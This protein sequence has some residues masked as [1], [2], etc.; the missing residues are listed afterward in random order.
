[1][2]IIALHA[3]NTPDK[4]ALVEGERTLTW[5]DLV[6]HRNRL[7]SALT[8]LGVV[9]GER[10]VVYSFN[11]IE[12][13]L[14]GLAATAVGCVSVPM[15]HRLTAEEAA[16]V[17]DNS[18]AVAV[19]VGD[20]FLPVVEEIRATA[21]TK[22]RH[23]ILVGEER[24]EW[25]EHIDDLLAAGRPE[26][27]D[28]DEP[29]GTMIYTAGTTGKPKGALRTSLD[30]TVVFGWLQALDLADPGHVHLAAGPLYHSAPGGFANFTLM[31]GG[32]VV[33]MPRFD[34]EAA[35]D[36]IERHRC[37]ST[38]MAPTLVKRLVE[39][40]E[41]V[42]AGH[43][44][45]S[46][47]VMVVAAAPCPMKVKEDVISWLGPVFYEFYGSTELGI[48]TILRPEDVLR[49]PGSCGR[50]APGIEVAVLDDDGNPLGPDQPGELHVRR[51][52]GMFEQYHKNDEATREASRGDW[53]SV[54][55]V[56]YTDE[57][58]FVYVCDRK[59]DMIISGGVNIYPAEIEDALHRHPQVHDV[60]VFG[61]PDE[62]WGERIHAAVQPR[63]GE[64]LTAEEVMAFARRHLAGYKVPREVSFHDDFPRD[65]AGKL[66]K[67][68]LREPFWAGR[69][70]QV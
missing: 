3:G 60:A 65:T 15:N 64:T 53:V 32:T 57:E 33:V 70:V 5:A 20:S 55:D 10:L 17:L 68:T 1:M 23:W 39:L 4:A 7:A 44:L 48:N 13:L 16:Y 27:L 26:P 25:A 66:I 42:R 62:E 2:D 28:S 46:M 50:G 21:A 35:L 29:G 51:Y 58:G 69:A 40:P 11:S 59:R 49:K 9:P 30:P 31:L 34:P 36:L 19:F 37:T 56:A 45:S 67:R 12:W 38:F 43:D 54:G 6:A 18:D 22:V 14:A 41:E 24:R 8:G 63:P 47:R 61:V 52:P